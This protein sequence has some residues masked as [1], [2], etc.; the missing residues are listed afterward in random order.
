MVKLGNKYT[1]KRVTILHQIALLMV[2]GR[3]APGHYNLSS[4]FFS[5]FNSLLLLEAI[6]RLSRYYSWSVI[7]GLQLLHLPGRWF[8]SDDIK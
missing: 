2:E 1:T 8:P 7:Q 5:N 3:L 6:S 4:A